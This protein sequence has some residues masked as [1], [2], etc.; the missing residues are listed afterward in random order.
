MSDGLCS[1]LTTT[2]KQG[3]ALALYQILYFL[4]LTPPKSD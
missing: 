2:T 3:R 4:H 1:R